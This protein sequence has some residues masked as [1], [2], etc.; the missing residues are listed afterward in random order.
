MFN[1]LWTILAQYENY[2]RTMFEQLLDKFC[3]KCE[4]F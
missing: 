2:K 1:K 4:Q 3:T